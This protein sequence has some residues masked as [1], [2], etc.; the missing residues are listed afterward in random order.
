MASLASEAGREQVFSLDG[1]AVLSG[2]QWRGWSWHLGV[3]SAPPLGSTAGSPGRHTST[4]HMDCDCGVAEIRSRSS[5]VLCPGPDRR[6][7]CGRG[8]VASFA[9]C[10]CVIGPE[11]SLLTFVHWVQSSMHL[12]SVPVLFPLDLAR[13]ILWRAGL[14]SLK[15]KTTVIK[16]TVFTQRQTLVVSQLLRKQHS[17]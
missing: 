15:N 6:L 10:S 11:V 12:G 5:G 8:Q 1:G 4:R 16:S 2:R 7:F 13:S 9:L 17:C 14:S 3:P